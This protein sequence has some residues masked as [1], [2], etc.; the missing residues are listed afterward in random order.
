M[1][2]NLIVR[3]AIPQNLL[4]LSVT[5][6]VMY[7]CSSILEQKCSRKSCRK[8]VSLRFH[9]PFS[10]SWLSYTTPWVSSPCPWS[11]FTLPKQCSLPIIVV[12]SCH[13][14][15]DA[16][17]NSH[18]ASWSELHLCQYRSEEEGTVVTCWE[19]GLPAAGYSGHLSAPCPR[20]F[21][22]NYLVVQPFHTHYKWLQYNLDLAATGYI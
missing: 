12:E 2:D 3:F 7:S 14:G 20:V 16:G 10:S 6:P 22:C 13:D 9:F 4:L 18:T 1:K 5:C 15:G 17:E 11:N 8:A 19:E 21:Q